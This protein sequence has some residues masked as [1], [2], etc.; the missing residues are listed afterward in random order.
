MQVDFCHLT[1]SPLERIL[2]RI[3]KKVL[4]SGERLLAVT[5]EAGQREALDRVLWIWSPESFPPQGIAS[6]GFDS[7]PP[8]LLA[9]DPAR[10]TTRGTPPM[11][12]ASGARRG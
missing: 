6:A 9:G 7:S 12:T 3:A 10:R 2:P 4:A 8:I 5:K 11:R 1:I